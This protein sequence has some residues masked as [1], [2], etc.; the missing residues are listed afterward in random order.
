M[1][2]C[3]NDAGKLFHILPSHN[4]ETPISK[5]RM[6]MSMERCSRHPDWAIGWQ[7]STRYDGAWP[8]SDL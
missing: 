6:L 8:W 2:G 1:S 5:L 7:S 3:C 4:W